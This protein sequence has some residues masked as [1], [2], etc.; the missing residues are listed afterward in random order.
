MEKIKRYN[1]DINKG[2][3]N[4]QIKERKENNLVN[5]DTTKKSKSIKAI[6]IENFFTIFNLINLILAI[7]VF[8]VGSYKNM[9][10]IG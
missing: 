1:S 7:A 3:T 9:L 8:C 4:E 6:I 10:F 5:K 2:L